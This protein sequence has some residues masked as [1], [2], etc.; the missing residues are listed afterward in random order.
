VNRTHADTAREYADYGRNMLLFSM[1]A[2]NY[3]SMRGY[4]AEARYYQDASAR[5]YRA[6]RLARGLDAPRGIEEGV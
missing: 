6:D 2:H 1:Q 5:Y 3:D 4:L